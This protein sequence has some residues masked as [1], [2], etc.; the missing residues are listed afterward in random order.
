ML[1]SSM[2]AI[3]SPSL[4]MTGRR[5]CIAALA[6]LA[7]LSCK[8]RETVKSAEA[9]PPDSAAVTERAAA[10]R[11]RHDSVVRSRPGYVIDSILPVDEEIRRFQTT[12]RERPVRLSHGAESRSALL[13]RFVEAVERKDT[14]ALARL[15]V[16]RAEF[17]YLIYPSSPNVAPPYRQSPEL[18]WLSRSAATDKGMTRLLARFGGKSMGY[19]GYVCGGAVARQGQNTVWSGCAVKRVGS[20][21]DTTQI[22]LF[23]PIVER[24]GRFKFLSLSNGL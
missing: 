5:L 13:R 23:G 14:T 16:S 9:A 10:E 2:I 22:R 6:G 3:P 21:G 1:S 17:G 18:V 20:A 7:S 8:G 15:V 24:H 4:G 19:A 11:A 12:V